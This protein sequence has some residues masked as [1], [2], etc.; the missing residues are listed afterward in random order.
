[1]KRQ[2]RLG[3]NI[4]NYLNLARDVYSEYIHTYIV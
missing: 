3:E 2:D 1:M 4:H